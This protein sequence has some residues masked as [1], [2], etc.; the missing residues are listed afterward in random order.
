MKASTPEAGGGK[1]W[2]CPLGNPLK[3]GYTDVVSLGEGTHRRVLPRAGDAAVPL[4]GMR[5]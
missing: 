5:S 4:V 3:A 2:S 1:P